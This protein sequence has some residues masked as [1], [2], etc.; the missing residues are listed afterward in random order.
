[1]L[2]PDAANQR[3]LLDFVSKLLAKRGRLQALAVVD[4]FAYE[5]LGL[6][7]DTS[8]PGLRVGRELDRIIERRGC[9]PAMVVS[10]N[11]MRL[12]LHAISRW[13]EEQSVLCHT[14]A[15]G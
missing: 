11:G 14:T 3:W 15:P 13:Q 9:H 8:L 12:T 10:D 2:L 4:D 6:V 5:C 7:V 1:M